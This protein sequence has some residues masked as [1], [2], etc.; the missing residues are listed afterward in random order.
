MGKRRLRL[1][2]VVAERPPGDAVQVIICC[3]LC[4]GEG[5]VWDG[6][7]R[8]PQQCPDCGGTGLRGFASLAPA[9][10]RS[11]QSQEQDTDHG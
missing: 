10:L 7:D 8:L 3:S 4:D 2:Y 5:S 9:A 1:K 11:L 6:T